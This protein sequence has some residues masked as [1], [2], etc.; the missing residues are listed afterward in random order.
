M[1][2]SRACSQQGHGRGAKIAKGVLQRHTADPHEVPGLAGGHYD[3]D[4][5]PGHARQ[6]AEAACRGA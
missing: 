4:A 2:S 5:E 6:H 1:T 3:K